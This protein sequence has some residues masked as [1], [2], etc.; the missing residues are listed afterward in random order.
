[1]RT[2]RALVALVLAG[3]LVVTG[4]SGD[5]DARG[6][7]DAG[8]EASTAPPPDPCALLSTD[9][10]AELTG[11]PPGEGTLRAVAPDQRKSCVFDDGLS[12]A[13]EVGEG[14]EA[15]VE[16][17]RTTPGESAVEDVEGLGS[18]AIWQ[19]FGDGAGQLVADGDDYFVGV[20]VSSG[21]SEVG[22]AVAGAMLA[23]L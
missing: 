3:A 1:M 10:L 7:T 18:A 22:S 4:C 20:T 17:I 16:L 15:T 6:G 21:G 23:A 11:V 8:D 5:D 12:L 19:D 2:S 13:V 9:A 14:Y